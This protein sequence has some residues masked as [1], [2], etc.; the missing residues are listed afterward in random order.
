[1]CPAE[2]SCA[3]ESRSSDGRDFGFKND[4]ASDPMHDAVIP[5]AAK[6]ADEILSAQITRDFHPFARISSRTKCRRITEG[7]GLWSKKKAETA[8]RT[9]VLRLSQF[10]P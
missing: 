1:M 10:S 2:G 8:S 6:K 7:A 3:Q 5:V 9:F 4:V